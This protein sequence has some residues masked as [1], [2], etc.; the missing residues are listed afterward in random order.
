ML[1]R[2]VSR[3]DIID[4]CVHLSQLESAGL[5][6][7]QGIYDLSEEKYSPIF[8]H[9]LKSIYA[10]LQEGVIFSQALKKHP[11]AF[12]PFFVQL[13]SVGEKT[14][15][16]APYLSQLEGHYRWLEKTHEKTKKAIT[17]PLVLLGCLIVLIILMTQFLVP[18]LQEYLIVLGVGELPFSTRL[19]ISVVEN[20]S[21]ISPIILMGGGGIFLSLAVLSKVYSSLK[22]T[23][24]QSLYKIPIFG[25]MIAQLQIT[26]FLS[27]LSVMLGAKVD[28]IT[29]FRQSQQSIKNSYLKKQIDRSLTEIMGGSTLSGALKRIKGMSPFLQRLVLLGE[30]SGDLPTLLHQGTSYQLHHVFY[31]ID[32]LIRWIEPS[33][34][35][36][37]GSIMIWIVSA[38]LL[39]LYSNISSV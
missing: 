26:R 7:A 21:T 24:D 1:R 35:L 30:K 2:S 29:A 6:I 34:L 15:C 9:V 12:D 27:G 38:I 31:K 32:Q 39:P 22:I 3:K 18:A 20:I 19:L 25:E 10:S 28:L 5:P 4:F 23:L 13:M 33:L 8:R 11:K 14:G 16:Y 17:Y 37:M 36:F